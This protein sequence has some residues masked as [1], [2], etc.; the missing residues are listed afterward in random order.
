MPIKNVYIYSNISLSLT[1]TDTHIHTH[2]RYK[3]VCYIT[4]TTF[5]SCS[6]VNSQLLGLSAWGGSFPV[7][8]QRELL[9]PVGEVTEGVR[10]G[11]V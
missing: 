7:F 5:E 8:H 9:P 10:T 3:N 6:Q 11:E 1:D 2:T 4:R